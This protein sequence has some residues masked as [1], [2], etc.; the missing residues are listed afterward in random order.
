MTGIQRNARVDL[1]DDVGVVEEIRPDGV[2]IVSS[3]LSGRLFEIEAA[4]ARLALEEVRRE[5]SDERAIGLWSAMVGPEDIELSLLA[6]YGE[7]GRDAGMEALR[8]RAGQDHV[9]GDPLPGDPVAMATAGGTLEGVAIFPA[10]GRRLHVD[11][12]LADGTVQRTAVPVSHLNL[13]HTWERRAVRLIRSALAEIDL[14]M[15][16]APPPRK[17]KPAAPANQPVVKPPV[18]NVHPLQRPPSGDTGVAID[19]YPPV[20]QLR[21]AS[22]EARSWLADLVEKDAKIRTLEAEAKDLREQIRAIVDE[23]PEQQRKVEVEKEKTDV[24]VEK[25]EVARLLH[26]MLEEEMASLGDIRAGVFTRFQAELELTA[27]AARR[28]Y[29][30]FLTFYRKWTEEERRGSAEK[31]AGAKELV[32]IMARRMPEHLAEIAAAL[33]EFE[34]ANMGIR[35][36]VKTILSVGPISEEYVSTTR[37]SMPEGV[38]AAPENAGVPRRSQDLRALWDRARQAVRSAWASVVSAV[39]AAQSAVTGLESGAGEIRQA[40]ES[41]E[42]AIQSAVGGAR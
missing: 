8:H 20:E 1:G 33:E 42:Q 15:T 17:R 19:S 21:E 26:E 9:D 10:P 3:V 34:K 25:A 16:A 37:P 13:P 24:E 2:L 14:A 4:H 18:T 41:L 22:E 35:T 40:R 32:A 7:E 12:S 29:S 31:L 23:L 36:V 39:E 38:P 30:H 5:Q 27:E 6:E 28:G 11:W